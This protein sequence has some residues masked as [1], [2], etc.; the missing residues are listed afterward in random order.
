[1]DTRSIAFRALA[2]SATLTF[3]ACGGG[4]D[5][6]PPP[7]SYRAIPVS[8]GAGTATVEGL[9]LAP[10]GTTP[11]GGAS[12]ALASAAGCTALTADD[13]SFKL[14][15]VPAGATTATATK[16]LFGAS[17]A[18]TPGTFAV[19]KVAAGSVSLAYVPGAWDSIED[20]VAR[21]GFTPTE[22]TA[23]DL[24]TADLTVYDAVLLD[25]GLDESYT[26]DPATQANLQ[27]YASAGGRLYA[28]DYAFTYVSAA[29]P[30][31]INFLSPNP[32]AGEP[33]DN[34]IAAIVDPTLA[35]ALGKTTA[36]INFN[37]DGWVVIDS[38]PVGTNVLLTGPAIV[39]DPLAPPPGLVTLPDK[40]YAVQ[41]AHG[42][43]RVT[44]TSF[45]NEAQTTADMDR[46]LEQMLFAL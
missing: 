39:Y 46:L 11:I 24:G 40:P 7:P 21:L 37:L 5:D 20:V 29:F 12:V 36:A 8:C 32:Y 2:A 9:F 34:Q 38:A 23:A 27:A 28:S 43:G 19:L 1:M 25:C 3:F 16:G 17:M 35:A 10:N 30:G 4:G 13:G 18:V 33:A 44:Y 22:I 26:S 15:N 14:T 45:H 6:G 31:K 41:F 42:S